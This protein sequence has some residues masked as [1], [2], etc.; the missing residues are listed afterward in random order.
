MFDHILWIFR[1][2]VFD[3]EFW[4]LDHWLP[5]TSRSLTPNNG[6]DGLC[7]FVLWCWVSP[8]K[9]RHLAPEP[10]PRAV[11]AEALDVATEFGLVCVLQFG[12]LYHTSA[13]GQWISP[14]V[15]MGAGWPRWVNLGEFGLRSLPDMESGTC[16]NQENTVYENISKCW[17]V[18]GYLI[19]CRGFGL[20]SLLGLNMKDLTTGKMMTHLILGYLGYLGLTYVRVRLNEDDGGTAQRLVSWF[21]MVLY[22]HQLYLSCSNPGATGQII[23]RIMDNPWTIPHWGTVCEAYST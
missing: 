14:L 15:L 6:C 12:R 7:M 2:R 21:Q 19:L 22:F 3:S 5:M 20:V 8:T 17:N 4:P 23:C 13:G 1:Y 11:G 10:R 18:S 9:D 16:A